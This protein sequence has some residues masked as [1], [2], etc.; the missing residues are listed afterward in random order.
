M[1]LIFLI[2]S[3]YVLLHFIFESIV[4][5]S[6]RFNL[7]LDLFQLRDKARALRIMNPEIGDEAFNAVQDGLNG[8]IKYLYDIDVPLLIHCDRMVERDPQ[9]KARVEKR[10]AIVMAVNSAELIEIF[11][12]LRKKVESAAMIN[13]G[14][15]LLYLIPIAIGMV[16]LKRVCTPIFSVLYLSSHELERIFP[17]KEIELAPA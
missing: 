8:A 17:P 6:V 1:A 11:S 15:W 2:F 7:R 10:R 16:I 3:V 12:Q 14:G 13:N 5:P 9:L 4:A